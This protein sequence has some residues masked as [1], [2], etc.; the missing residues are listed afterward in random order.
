M[1]ISSRSF[2]HFTNEL[3]FLQGILAEGFWPRYCKEYGWGE[4]YIDFAIPMVCFCNIPLSQIIEHSNFYGNYGIGV[5]PSWITNQKTITPVQYI[6][7]K[8]IEFNRIRKIL[9]KLK[10]GDIESPEIHKLLLAKKVCGKITDKVGDVH[11][12]KL[13][14]EREWRFIPDKLKEDELIIPIPKG[15]NEVDVTELSKRTKN[16]KL[17]IDIDSISYIFIPNEYSREKIINMIGDVYKEEDELKR[18][19]L[20]S[21]IIT[22]KQIQDDF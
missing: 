3:E 21:K 2:F 6:P 7:N 15:H 16:L 14:D 8:S 5:S 4:K 1:S 18:F 17:K 9:T 13:Y 12:K 10:N 11:T 20:M 22:L 19:I